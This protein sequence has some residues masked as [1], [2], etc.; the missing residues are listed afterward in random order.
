MTALYQYYPA[1]LTNLDLA[2]HEGVFLPLDCTY[3]LLSLQSIH[4]PRTL[5]RDLFAGCASC[6][7][8]LHYSPVSAESVD[9]ESCP[10]ACTEG[11]D[12]MSPS[13]SSSAMGMP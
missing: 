13:R 5:E 9:D 1:G 6:P 12:Y 3:G 8:F 4:E 10:L 7:G 11:G 2:A